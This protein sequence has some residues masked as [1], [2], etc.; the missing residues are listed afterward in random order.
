M[1]ILCNLLGEALFH[2][3]NYT[4]PII[5]LSSTCRSPPVYMHIFDVVGERLVFQDLTRHFIINTGIIIR[6]EPVAAEALDTQDEV[7]YS[8][9]EKG[10]HQGKQLLLSPDGYTYT[11][12]K[13][14]TTLTG[15]VTYWKCSHR[16]ESCKARVTARVSG[17]EPKG[18][19]NH[20]ADHETNRKRQLQS[21]IS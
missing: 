9:L 4:P 12:D 8:I 14:K 18:E 20:Q 1:L 6:G 3:L 19:H 5:I 13:V 16:K 15:T 2:D 11:V 10:T 7:T 21:K 17:Y